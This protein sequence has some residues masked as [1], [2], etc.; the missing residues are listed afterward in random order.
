MDDMLKI[1]KYKNTENK[2]TNKLQLISSGIAQKAN[3][4]GLF[5]LG[6]L[7]EEQNNTRIGQITKIL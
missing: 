5:P 4:T 7:T 2:K 3:Y 1:Q 6:S